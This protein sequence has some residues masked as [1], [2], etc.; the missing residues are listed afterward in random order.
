MANTCI[1]AYTII[2]DKDKVRVI[3]DDLNKLINKKREDKGPK[4]YM[5]DS[6]WLGWIVREILCEDSDKIAC[7]GMFY[8]GDL[9]AG[10]SIFHVDTD[11]AWEPCRMLFSQL[12]KKYDV[13]IFYCAE[14]LSCGIYETND[15][16][17][18][19]YPERI[20]VESD[21]GSEYF[22]SQD[23]AKQYIEKEMGVKFDSWYLASNTDIVLE[24]FSI[25]EVE[26][27]KI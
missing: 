18:K 24:R 11:T 10:D 12:A 22:N 26:V 17:G 19:Y 4:S 7:R 23:D 27:V 1:T 21:D 13:E 9:S 6:N 14:E 8:L 2:G 25:F 20:I 16:E 15:A 3:H 5:S